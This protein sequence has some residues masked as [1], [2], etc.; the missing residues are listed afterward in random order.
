MFPMVPYHAL[1]RLH[2]AIRHDLPEANRSVPQAFAEVLGALWRQLRDPEYRI[3]KPLPPT[4][5]PYRLDLH[6]AA[7]GAGAAE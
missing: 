5:R 3:E 4:A 7:L 1:P 6:A 2:E